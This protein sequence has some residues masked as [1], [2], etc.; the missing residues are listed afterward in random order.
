MYKNKTVGIWGF[1]KVGS[2]TAQFLHSY[3]ATIIGMDQ[4]QISHAL[5]NTWFTQDQKDAFFAQSDFIIASPGIDISPYYSAHK[6]K[7]LTE[8]DLFHQHWQKTVLAITGSVGKT[9]VTTL[10]GQ[11]MTNHDVRPAVAGNIGTPMLEL[12][13]S[14]NIYDLAI[15]EVSSFQLEYCTSFAPDL[16]LWT[17]FVPNHLD[18]HT[19]EQY[20]DAKANIFSHQT[21][22]Q[23]AIIPFDLFARLSNRYPHKRYIVITENQISVAE[24]DHIIASEHTLFMLEDTIL[25]K[26][27]KNG[28]QELLAMR[29]MPETTFVSNWL[30]ICAILDTLGHDLDTLSEYA[31]DLSIPEHRMEKITKERTTFYNDSKATTPTSTLSA[32]NRLAGQ[33]LILFLGGLSKGIDRSHLVNALRGKVKRIYCFGTEAPLLHQWCNDYAIPSSAHTSLDEA[34]TEC[35]RNKKKCEVI[36]FSPSGSSY[37]LFKDYEVRGTYFKQLITDY[38]ESKKHLVI[39]T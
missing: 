6:H 13:K 10:L 3:G 25:C 19:I 26:Y 15:L 9:S 27:T 32:I 1:G 34:F 20:F 22:Q 31:Q 17:N 4:K 38:F 21:D 5:V 29:T 37:D 12:I 18:R 8:L 35:M 24:K 14:R 30:A 28:R 36:L 16:A 33:E 2:S 23:I 11:L 39:R 7:W